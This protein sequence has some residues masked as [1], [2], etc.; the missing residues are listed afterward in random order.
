[1][2]VTR[3]PMFGMDQLLFKI[4]NEI[5]LREHG[6][7]LLFLPTLVVADKHVYHGNLLLCM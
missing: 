2:A 7:Y 3:P 6:D 5:L 4:L 1:M